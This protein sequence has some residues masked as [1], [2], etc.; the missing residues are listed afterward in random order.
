M[1]KYKSYGLSLVLLAALVGCNPA[2]IEVV[3]SNHI[4]ASMAVNSRAGASSDNVLQFGMFLTNPQSDQHSYEN[5]LMKRGLDGV[6]TGTDGQTGAP[7]TMLWQNKTTPVEVIAYAPYRLDCTATRYE[8]AV[9]ADQSTEA[10]LML[11]DMVCQATTIHP[12]TDLTS[13]GSMA[14]AL[15][16]VLSKLDVSIDCDDAIDAVA[17]GENPVTS[18]RI[19]GSK[20]GYVLDPSRGDIQPTGA[21]VAVVPL[22]TSAKPLVGNATY[23]AIL[24]P[25][26][27]AP[28][29]FKVV[30]QVLDE[31]YTYTMPDPLVL[32]KNTR[33]ALSI[34]ITSDKMVFA[35]IETTPWDQTYEQIITP[36]LNQTIAIN[37]QRTTIPDKSVFDF[38]KKVLKMSYRGG[39]ARINFEGK[40]DKVLTV[41]TPDPRVTIVASEQ[42]KYKGEELIITATQPKE[43]QEY[44][45]TFRVAN[46]LL[47]AIHFMDVT[48]VV[49]SNSIPSVTIGQLEVMAY[50]GCGRSESLYPPLEIDQTVR[51][52]YREQWR[53]YSANCMWG[54][55]VPPLK[56]LIYPWQVIRTLNSLGGTVIGGSVTLWPD[57]S[58]SIP[59]PD[60][61]RV[62]TQAEVNTFW[63]N[64]NT[65][66]T[67][68]YT[69][70]GITFNASIEDSGAADI[71]ADATTTISPRIYVIAFAGQELIFPMTGWRKRDDYAGRQ[72]LPAISAG[73]AFYIWTQDKGP[74]NYTGSVVG[75]NTAGNSLN[76]RFNIQETYAEAYN[77][78]RCVRTIK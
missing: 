46:S 51:D 25:Q 64:H 10:A 48:V 19:E 69:K 49:M 72:E 76:G 77:G 4:S 58:R 3:Q 47:P 73:E 71:V 30:M 6:F 38:D 62:P 55:R 41:S 74:A 2:E 57:D 13:T 29:G 36:D 1:N 75:V 44:S 12:G 63:P 40:Y 16:H 59:C 22:N 35:Q 5:V 43:G 66:A 60:G 26:A 28:S 23:E 31:T 61:W 67:G 39:V 50:N 34:K 21:A 15:D 14:L 7:L 33:Y 17:G 78:V 18:V 56:E 52:V 37:T 54:D 42:T 32:A 45:V 70:G 27:I 53:K 68:Q 20:V 24:V 11:S 65:S 9:E 8:S